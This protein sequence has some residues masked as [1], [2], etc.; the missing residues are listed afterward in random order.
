[1]AYNYNNVDKLLDKNKR[2]H[3]SEMCMP[4][5]IRSHGDLLMESYIQ[6]PKNFLVI[7]FVTDGLPVCDIEGESAHGYETKC[8]SRMAKYVY[9]WNRFLLN[10]ASATKYNNNPSKNF[11]DIMNENIQFLNVELQDYRN[12]FNVDDDRNLEYTTVYY[13]GDLICNTKYTYKN[14]NNY[15]LGVT[16]WDEF[17]KNKNTLLNPR[18]PELDFEQTHPLHGLIQKLDPQN[19]GV[20]YLNDIMNQMVEA[21]DNTDIIRIIFSFSCRLLIDP[22]EYNLLRIKQNYN[23][24][25]KN[26]F[27]YLNHID[28]RMLEHNKRFNYKLFQEN[29]NKQIAKANNAPN[30]LYDKFCFGS[31]MHF[32]TNAK[33]LKTNSFSIYFDDISYSNL[34]KEK[35]FLYTI[36]NI[37]IPVRNAKGFLMDFNTYYQN[38]NSNELN[39]KTMFYLPNNIVGQILWTSFR[40][41]GIILPYYT[42]EMWND[43]S[44]T[45]IFNEWS[46]LIYTKIQPHLVNEYMTFMRSVFI[47][48]MSI[49]NI[50]KTYQ[51]SQ[52]IQM[53][54]DGYKDHYLFLPYYNINLVRYYILPQ[55]HDE[56]I[57]EYK[58]KRLTRYID[59]DL[60]PYLTP[61]EYAISTYL[62]L[63]ENGQSVINSVDPYDPNTN[64]EIMLD[65]YYNYDMYPE[66]N[67]YG[68]YQKYARVYQNVLKKIEDFMIKNNLKNMSLY[69][70]FIT[71]YLQ[72]LNKYKDYRIPQEYYDIKVYSGLQIMTA[73]YV[74]ENDVIKNLNKYKLPI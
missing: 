4:I 59:L 3:F 35:T 42:Y 27:K 68:N 10:I 14:D 50:K 61:V 71:Y 47:H 57:K 30:I 63:D 74:L 11:I 46:R 24:L 29:I 1:M 43:R 67:F 20:L 23:Y 34:K 60:F 49:E 72:Y 39:E 6:I 31:I 9:I 15:R 56:F 45:Y 7:T 44:K 51:Q 54:C 33:K 25:Y 53:L 5:V 32:S 64:L 40:K 13:P 22:L 65:D 2:I 19:N 73:N 37:H 69:D 62:Y 16:S 12:E 55:Y 66:I 70:I 48:N 36:L 38:S 28:K 21:T 41:G 18:L 58:S 52:N 8:K 17:L 26:L